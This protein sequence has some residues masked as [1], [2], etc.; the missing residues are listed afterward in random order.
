LASARD[1]AVLDFKVTGRC[2]KLLRRESEHCPPCTCSS[3]AQLQPRDLN[4]EAAPGWA[5][6]GCEQ[7]IALNDVNRRERYVELVGHHL[8]QRSLDAG[9]QFDMSAIDGHLTIP[10]DCEPRVHRFE[11]LR[12]RKRRLS[13]RLAD[14]AR[15]VEAHHQRATGLEELP[16]RYRERSVHVM[17]PEPRASRRRQCADEY[18]SGTG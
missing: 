4:R 7:R 13:E 3:L 5:L 17:L 9:A 2:A 11:V 1:H 6:I 10:A 18:H 16:A 15:K 8:R 14:R 12:D